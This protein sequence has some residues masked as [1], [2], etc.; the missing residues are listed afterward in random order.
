MTGSHDVTTSAG[1]RPATLPGRDVPPEPGTVTEPPVLPGRA[2]HDDEVPRSLVELMTRGWAGEGELDV[3]PA[4][5]APFHGRRRRTL[6]QH[7]PGDWLL[8]PTGPLKVRANDTDYRFRAGTDFYWLTG[9]M[10]PD[11]VLVM[12]PVPDGHRSTLFMAPRSDRSTPAFFTDRRY[13]ELWVGA[14]PGLEETSQRL[15]VD[16]APLE[17]LD[18]A[19]ERAGRGEAPIR[20]LRGFDS[21]VDDR[22]DSGEPADD[23]ADA[24]LAQVLSELRLVKDEHEVA[25][26]EEAVAATVRGFEDVVRELPEAV[27]SSER[28]VEGTF[29]RR[30]RVEGHD[31]G[32]DTIAAAG[33]HAC[34]LHWTV[35]D[36]PVR[37]GELLLL[38]A[39]VESRELYTADVTRTL[40]ISGEWSPQQRAVYQ[41]V[42]RAQQA[43]LD[44]VRPGADFRAPHRAAMA[45]IAGW[46][47]EVGILPDVEDALSPEGQLH[48]R[49]TLHGTSHMLGLDVHDC[50]Q[51]REEQYRQGPLRPGY[52]LTVEP[53]LYF[54]PD[55]LTVPEEYR[56]I[57][58]RIEDDVLVTEDG[59]RVLSA[60]L[61][62]DPDEI[63]AWMAALQRG[64]A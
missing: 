9:L 6:S 5:S 62:R 1:Q 53:G 23:A 29:Y 28:Y 26:L 43:G 45:V 24:E 2:S 30:A 22:F 52:V 33:V 25:M 60:A 3:T 63:V 16:T 8:V 57:G 47:V 7:F 50:A 49:Y 56:G 17:D 32:Y 11:C 48:K 38:D 4:A 39:G 46:L 54:Q 59:C 35:N 14:R 31:V 19:L 55:D 61:P 37:P 27:A 42:L 40:P 51:A 21:R 15:R 10:E 18:S 12:E 44:A 36:G 13:G 41:V 64:A 20:V 58:V 34:T